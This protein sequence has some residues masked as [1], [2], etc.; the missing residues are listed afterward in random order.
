[1]TRKRV[2]YNDVHDDNEG[3]RNDMDLSVVTLV[4]SPP[5]SQYPHHGAPCVSY[6]GLWVPS[7]I[8]TTNGDNRDNSI[9]TCVRVMIT[10]SLISFL[11]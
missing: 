8:V 9:L 6:L 2:T 7:V 3:D 4:T 1:M 11:S 5:Q 10:T